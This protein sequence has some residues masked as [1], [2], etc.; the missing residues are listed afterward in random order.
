MNKAMKRGL[1]LIIMS[2]TLLTICCVAT[3]MA[4]AEVGDAFIVDCLTYEVTT[5]SP[6]PTVAVVDCPED[7]K[8]DVNIHFRATNKGIEYAVTKIGK[9]AFYISDEA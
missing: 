6:F 2:T 1:Q 9:Y 4:L 7:Y 8:G 3:F 5:P